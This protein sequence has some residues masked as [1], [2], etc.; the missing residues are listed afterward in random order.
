MTMYGIV[1]NIDKLSGSIYMNMVYTG[2]IRLVFGACFSEKSFKASIEQDSDGQ[3]I[4]SSVEWTT[5][6]HGLA[7]N[8]YTLLDF[9]L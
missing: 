9:S 6:T 5:N 3:L 7:E 2:L 8:S 4:Y 1:F